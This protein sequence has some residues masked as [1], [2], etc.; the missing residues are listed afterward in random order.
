M[1]IADTP[2]CALAFL[3]D[4]DNKTTAKEIQDLIDLKT[5]EKE[6]KNYLMTHN[7]EGHT[8]IA[9]VCTPNEGE[10]KKTLVSLGFNPVDTFTRR[11]GYPKGNLDLLILD[12]HDYL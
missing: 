6:A 10:L 7:G 4:V 1:K 12:L 8:A 2:C 5:K 11:K 9:V 3:Y